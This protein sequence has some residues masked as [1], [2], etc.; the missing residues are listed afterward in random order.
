MADFRFLNSRVSLQGRASAVSSWL[1][2][3][4]ARSAL[5]LQLPLPRP[6]ARPWSLEQAS[7]C[8]TASSGAEA[9]LGRRLALHRE[10]ARR[11]PARRRRPPPDR[12]GARG[13]RRALQPRAPHV[14]VPARAGARRRAGRGH[15][16]RVPRRSELRPRCRGL[17]R[18]RLLPPA[19][20]DPLD[21]RSR[22]PAQRRAPRDGVPVRARTIRGRGRGGGDGTGAGERRA[23]APARRARHGLRRGMG[24][25]RVAALRPDDR[26]AARSPGLRGARGRRDRGEPPA[27]RDQH[28]VARHRTEPVGARRHWGGPS[29]TGASVSAGPPTSTCAWTPT[30]GSARARTATRSGSR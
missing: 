22:V 4:S 10:P 8:L 6:R 1:A 13:L 30:R 18:Q 17:H 29:P 5:L 20:H 11:R 25:G 26:V 24:R 27:R 3:P 16:A 7:T 19:G 14:L 15:P 2:L 28:R 9:G 23:R 21:R 12:A